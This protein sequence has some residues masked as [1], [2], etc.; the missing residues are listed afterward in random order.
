MNTTR[1][2]RFFEGR[3]LVLIVDD[4]SVNREMLGYML[5]NDYD[6]I[7]AENG[8]RALATI[9]E[10][11]EKLSLIM[12][13]VMMPEL[14][15]FELLQILKRDER[16]HRIPVIVLTME[17]SYEVRSL[18]LGAS[19]FIKMP[20]DLP[21]AVLARVK[22]TIE[23]S[24][25]SN[26]IQTTENDKLTGLYHQEYF[27]QY[28]EQYDRLYPER[29]MDALS[30]DISHFH[31][32][33]ELYGRSEGNAILVK[34]A[35]KLDEIV[36]EVDGIAC[37]KAADVFLVYCPHQDNYEE[38]LGRIQKAVTEDD[39]KYRSTVRLKMGIYLDV[40]KN[41][42]IRLR[43]D[44]AKLARD[45]IHHSFTQIIAFYDDSLH[46]KNL[47][48]QQLMN[49]MDRAL[50]ER[51]FRVYYQPKYTITGDEPVLSS[52]EAL[53]RWHHP[54]LG[55]ISPGV[56]IP[57]FE[58]NGLIPKLDRFAWREA[59][60]QIDAWREK[61][62]I[63]FP[64]SVN[65]SRIDMHDPDL[66]RIFTGIIE[67]FH[68]EPTDLLIEITESA[69][70]DH[71]PRIGE[72][73]EELRALGFRIEMDDFGSGYSSLNMLSQL[74]IDVIKLDMGFIRNVFGSDKSRQ[75]L[76]LMM[77]IKNFLN[78]PIVAEGV[79]TE[80]QLDFLREIGCD[81]VQGYY[82]SKPVEPEE[83]EKFIEEKMA[84]C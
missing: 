60:A 58:K 46:Q 71:S 35:Q 15:G 22:R 57:L 50:E 42:D 38:I 74:P 29:S 13:D 21:E 84:K 39:E 51:Q 7:Y 56:F 72:V 24:E 20:Y 9:E 80:E 54:T 45:T 37:R 53:I 47:L 5:S 2:S 18:Q 61:Y 75:I 40:D 43:F 32:I 23:M 19:D 55:I 6:V 79:E 59:A 64:I 34:L 4:E 67:E 36:R 25:D 78:V 65:V 11:Y 44:R 17:K 63:T 76:R 70:T 3:R 12:L 1:K 16:F 83:F 68:L 48:S 10:N 69:Y 52:A 26:I 30:I 8:A 31:M 49:E 28:A 27:F 33:N 62:G 66:I 82:F 41:V 14:N 77:Q 73:V 81:I